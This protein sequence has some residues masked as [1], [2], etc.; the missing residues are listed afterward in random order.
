MRNVPFSLRHLNTWSPVGNAVWGGLGDGAAVEEVCHWG[1]AL[2]ALIL[3]FPC[4][5]NMCL[6]FLVLRHA[7]LP[8]W[9][10]TGSQN[11]LKLP[12]ALVSYYSNR[13]AANTG[14]ISTRAPFFKTS[15]NRPLW[16]YSVKSSPL[17]R[18]YV[19]TW[20]SHEQHNLYPEEVLDH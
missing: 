17:S 2:T 20:S 18:A 4:G 15:S 13:K 3:C 10:P 9:T 14:A 6:S 19:S 11:K 12:L 8:S 1:Q 16:F 7:T 5:F